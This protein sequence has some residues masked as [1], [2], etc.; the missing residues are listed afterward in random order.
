MFFFLF[1]KK[2]L[3][4]LQKQNILTLLNKDTERALQKSS[5]SSTGYIPFPRE[6]Y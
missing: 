3:F 5:S 4:K 1:F 2:W 6:N